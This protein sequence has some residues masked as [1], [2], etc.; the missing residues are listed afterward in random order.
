MLL[1]ATAF[2]AFF[3]HCSTM[4][5][6]GFVKARIPSKFVKDDLGNECGALGYRCN[7][8]AKYDC[9]HEGLVCSP[10]KSFPDMKTCQKIESSPSYSP[11]FS[12][13]LSPTFSPS[14]SPTFSP[15]L[16]PTYNATQE[17]TKSCGALGY[18]C[19]G[20]AKYDCCNEGLVCSPMESFP[21]MK[22]C[23]KI[24]SSPSYSPT[25]SP[26]LSPTFSPSLSPTFSPSLSPTYN[27]TQEATKSCG[28]LGYRCNGDAKYDCCNEGLVC[29]PM[30]SFPD[31]KTCQKPG[32][33]L[34]DFNADEELAISQRSIL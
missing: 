27:A 3:L 20:D 21:D 4:D 26:S 17:A 32:E 30:K 10:M 19:N 1:K 9:C 24:E 14:L 23:Q 11:T 29:S 2:A 25:F 6:V 15:S 7:G 16:S 31:M 28:A 33:G 13:S 5:G 22:T 18:R 34:E 8:N 12:P